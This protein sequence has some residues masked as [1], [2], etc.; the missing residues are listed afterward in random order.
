MN[1]RFGRHLSEGDTESNTN[2]TPFDMSV[3]LTSVNAEIVVLARFTDERNIPLTLSCMDGF[4]SKLKES[5]ILPPEPRWTISFAADQTSK[6]VFCS[7]PT[8]G[9]HPDTSNDTLTGA[10]SEE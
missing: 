2:P 7:E 8:T 5:L 3:E 9:S 10:R 6:S 4:L 1:S